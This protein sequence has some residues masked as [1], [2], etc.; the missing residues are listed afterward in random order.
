[1][2]KIL[3]E[4]PGIGT[5]NLGD[6]IISESAKTQLNPLF[7]EDFVVEVSTRLP[8]NFYFGRRFKHFDVKLVL[9]SNILNPN[10]TYGYRKQWAISYLTSSMWGPA[11][12][13]GTGWSTYSE[14]ISSGQIRLW[15]SILHDSLLHAVR[16]TYTL[17]KLNSIGFKNVIYTA[18]PTM[19]SLT[20]EHC[21]LI[22]T[23]KAKHVVFTL[24]DYR[25]DEEKDRTLAQTLTSLYDNV[26]FWPQ[27][28]HDL[29]Y[30]RRILP[31]SCIRRIM[32]L[33]PSLAAY[34]NLLE[35]LP[36]LEFVGTRLHGGIRALQK[37]KRALIIS[38]DN[39]AMEI[40]RDV[41]IPVLEREKINQ[42]DLVLS[43]D[44]RYELSMPWQSIEQW[45]KQFHEQI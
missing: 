28:L 35:G 2:R 22:P 44:L 33:P 6:Q 10:P 40:H 41:N 18:C 32:V 27:G 11:V 8:L 34:D 14:R 4:N 36:E 5:F 25:P 17:E 39:R 31:E 19:W 20:P 38:V 37:G 43:S 24:T 23:E 42:L 12:M 16:D 13:V 29:D 3:Y 45:K 1:M 15:R 7:M 26:Y 21:R 9:G 30:F